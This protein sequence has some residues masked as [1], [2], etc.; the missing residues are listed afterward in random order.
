MSP[1]GQ[2]PPSLM[3]CLAG[4]GALRDAGIEAQEVSGVWLGACSPALFCNQEHLAPAAVEV[5]PEALRFKP[6]TRVEGA[7]ASSSV[8]LYSAAY[9][10]AS[11][12]FATALVIGVEKMSVLDT[13]G[14]THALACSS[15]W[16]E[17][18]G[19]GMTFAGLFA[20]YAKGYRARYGLSDELLRRMLATVAALCYRN[21]VE[22]PLAHFGPGSPPDRK[23][24]FD[25]EAILALPEDKNPIIA[26]PLRLHDCSLI[27]DGAAAVVL[28]S[29]ERARALK[30][31]VV[32]LAGLAHTEERLP[33]GVRPNMHELMAAKRARELAFQEVGISTGD[34]DLAEVHDCFT[35]NQLLCT[36]ALGLSADGRAGHDYMEGRFTRADRCPVNLSGGLKAKGHPVGATG[37][38]LHALVYKQLTGEPI[39]VPC[40][41][42]PEV[43]VV[44]NVGGSAVTNCLTVLRRLR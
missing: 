33:I 42:E 4:R 27:S 10:V 12:R 8:A 11:G 26:P 2:T 32:E 30:D 17:E 36:E 19:R 15:Y 22:N 13:A 7:C 31:R 3:G 21:G 9:A 14:V 43:G 20:E 44:L 34:M 24:L 18:G 28:T 23:R 38:S 6:M 1:S 5:D 40:L 37:A 16:P 35:I 29:T 41:R 39:G 25:A